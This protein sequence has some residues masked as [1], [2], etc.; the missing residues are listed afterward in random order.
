MQERRQP[1]GAV[2]YKHLSLKGRKTIEALLNQS[3]I[4]LKQ[5]EVYPEPAAQ[6]FQPSTVLSITA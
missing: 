2:R 1:Y 4:K 6:A 5:R 3:V